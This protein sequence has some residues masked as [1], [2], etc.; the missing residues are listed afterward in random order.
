[1]LD[2]PTPQ[3]LKD[4]L[5]RLFPKDDKRLLAL[6][7]CRRDSDAVKQLLDDI[8]RRCFQQDPPDTNG[9]RIAISETLNATVRLRNS[10]LNLRHVSIP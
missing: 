3:R 1:M 7:D 5:P 4:P 6:A 9:A 10:L 2:P 8:E